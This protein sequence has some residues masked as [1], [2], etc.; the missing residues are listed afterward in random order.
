MA[1]RQSPMVWVILLLLGAYGAVY[2][3]PWALERWAVSW[4]ENQ[5]RMAAAMANEQTLPPRFYEQVMSGLQSSPKQ[6]LKAD[7]SVGERVWLAGQVDDD[8]REYLQVGRACLDRDPPNP[9]VAEWAILNGIMRYYAVNRAGV[10]NEMWRLF[11]RSALRKGHLES[12]ALARWILKWDEHFGM[13]GWGWESDLARLGAETIT[14]DANRGLAIAPLGFERDLSWGWFN[15]TTEFIATSTTLCFDRPCVATVKTIAGHK[16]WASEGGTAPCVLRFQARGQW[17]YGWPPFLMIAA[18]GGWRL[19][20]VG[21]TDW[22]EH[23]IMGPKE[24]VR[25]DVIPL[26][27]VYFNHGAEERADHTQ[28]RSVEIRNMEWIPIKNS[29]ED[30]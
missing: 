9:Q 3:Y 26:T 23:V 12:A 11:E 19:V 17:A 20:V 4:G 16:E 7:G 5:N 8:W 22:E 25:A 6:W 15:P 21:A 29:E 2:L 28:R 13:P 24:W 30:G 14:V 27:M 18:G 1:W 10:E